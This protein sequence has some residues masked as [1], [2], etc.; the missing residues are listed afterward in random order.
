MSTAMTRVD[1]VKSM[2]A[3]KAAAFENALPATAR[4]YLTGDRIVKIVGAAMS[5]SKY[6]MECTNDSILRA[7]MD[8]SQLGLE[9]GGPLQQAHLV[10]YKNKH[11]GK[12]EAQCIVGYGGY[13]T[14]AR[15]SGDIANVVAN[16]VYEQDEFE[17]PDLASGARPV[18][19]PYMKGDRGDWYCAYCVATFKDGTIQVEFMTKDDIMKVKARSRA[20]SGP[21]ITDEEQMARKTV[22][23][24]ARKFWP[25]SS[26][27]M[28][29]LSMAAELEARAE[30]GEKTDDVIDVDFEEMKPKADELAETLA[31]EE[32]PEPEQDAPSEPEEAP[33]VHPPKEGETGLTLHHLGEIR[34]M[35][36]M[37]VDTWRAMLEENSIDD[38]DRRTHT[39]FRLENLEKQVNDWVREQADQNEPPPEEP[40]QKELAPKKPDSGPA[41]DIERQYLIQRCKEQGITAKK[42]IMLALKGAGCLKSGA[43]TVDDLTS[44]D[45]KS[46]LA[47]ADA[48]R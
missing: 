15:R 32:P 26:E 47:F 6:L 45:I 44:E 9:I 4:K 16:V 14:L 33:G 5:R 13:I 48:P 35:H 28:R 18:H 36:G 11:T 17:P 27:D 34:E 3:S 25:L 21:W 12:R 22:I 40:A 46:Y 39:E 43:T 2:L 29:M 7:V 41:P 37:D 24:R 30:A 19:K 38:G 42:D 23:R 31:A 8:A 1:Q 10:P 20:S